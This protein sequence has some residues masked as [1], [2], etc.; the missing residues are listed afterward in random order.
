M[1]G[2]LLKYENVAE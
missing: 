2:H 1:T